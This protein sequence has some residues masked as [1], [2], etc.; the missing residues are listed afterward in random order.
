MNCSETFSNPSFS[1]TSSWLP[2]QSEFSPE[3]AWSGCVAMA[4]VEK[5]ENDRLKWR[6]E[7]DKAEGGA[8]NL[9]WRRR[10]E[11]LESVRDTW[12]D[13]RVE[14]EDREEVVESRL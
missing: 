5:E 2:T 4:R 13:L 3:D 10:R 8:S 1:A 14:E 7:G 9:K 12:R 11:R 6:G